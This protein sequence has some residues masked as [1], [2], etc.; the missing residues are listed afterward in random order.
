MEH[1]T[2]RTPDRNGQHID[3]VSGVPVAVL[4]TYTLYGTETTH[5]T[6]YRHDNRIKR[7]SCGMYIKEKRIL[8]IYGRL[9]LNNGTVGR[10]QETRKY[11]NNINR[12]QRINVD[13]SNITHRRNVEI[14]CRS[15]RP[16][17]NCTHREHIKSLGA[18]WGRISATIARHQGRGGTM[19]RP[20]P[21]MAD[22]QPTQKTENRKPKTD[23]QATGRRQPVGNPSGTSRTLTRKQSNVR[24]F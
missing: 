9:E 2:Q 23:R 21:F 10:H 17:D 3:N 11:N 20:F 14:Y 5:K 16:V 18:E 15:C 6:D 13:C 22:T 19:A 12:R 4:N 7:L 24:N 1:N 8:R